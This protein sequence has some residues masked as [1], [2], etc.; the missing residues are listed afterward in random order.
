MKKC[1][2][3]I[4]ASFGMFGSQAYAQN[5]MYD[6]VSSSNKWNARSI[7]QTARMMVKDRLSEI[8]K[9]HVYNQKCTV[10]KLTAPLPGNYSQYR[11]YAATWKNGVALRVFE[12]S[13][14]L[15]V[16]GISKNGVPF[17]WN[18]DHKPIAKSK[19]HFIEECTQL[20]VNKVNAKNITVTSS[21][22]YDDLSGAN[23]EIT[24]I[25]TGGVKTVG[26]CLF[27]RTK[28]TMATSKVKSDKYSK[29]IYSN[30]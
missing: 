2:V 11:P 10:I 17:S 1:I 16:M 22:K 26:S 6:G 15:K 20:F 27:D 18:D 13:K 29:I 24:Y 9:K 14:G 7:C 8:E 3:I 5:D 21:K 30:Y 19:S 12:T 28:M 23:V 4:L 25:G